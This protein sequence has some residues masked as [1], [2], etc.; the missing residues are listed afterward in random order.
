MLLKN[1]DFDDGL[2]NGACGKIEDITEDGVI[3]QFDN[4]ILK[5]IK[6][7]EF[8]YMKDGKLL[9]RRIQYPLRLSYGITI[10]KSQGMTLDNVFIDFNRIFEYG[11]AY[12]ALSRVK[13]LTG[14]YLRGFNPQ[15]I[16]TNPKII[17]FYKNLE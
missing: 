9:A 3:V 12:V 11:Q 4:G 15:K 5:V 7:E 10:H 16:M 14:L 1:L 6:K 13:S 17:E 8:D 2:I